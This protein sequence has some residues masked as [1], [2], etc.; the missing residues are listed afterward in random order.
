MKANITEV[1]ERSWT[2]PFKTKSNFARQNADI[3]AMAASDGFI[4]TRIAAGFHGREWLI[5]PL[6]LS[7]FYA[8]SGRHSA[9]P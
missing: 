8:L 2:R 5:T 7:H 3:V 4:T 6:G 9:Q 1:L